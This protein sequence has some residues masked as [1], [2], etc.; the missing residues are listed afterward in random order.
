MT[1]FLSHQH[2]DNSVV[3]RY[4]EGLSERLGKEKVLLDLWNIA[5]GDSIINFMNE[6]LE[7]ATHFVLFWSRNAKNSGAVENE[8]QVALMRAFGGELDIVLVCLDDEPVPVVMRQRRYLRHQDGF[9]ECLNDLTNFAAGAPVPDATIVAIDVYYEVTFCRDDSLLIELFSV[10]ENAEIGPFMFTSDIHHSY[11]DFRSDNG[12][13]FQV[14]ETDDARLDTRNQFGVGFRFTDGGVSS[15]RPASIRVLKRKPCGPTLS[16]LHV[17]R[18]GAWQA[19]PLN[20]V[21]DRTSKLTS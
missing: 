10:T 16:R 5:P 3:L 12:R 7:Q 9:T 14:L 11:F 19:L 6:G 1:V 2:Q 21:T 17:Q 15:A 20:R 8:W 13:E 18:A 4:A